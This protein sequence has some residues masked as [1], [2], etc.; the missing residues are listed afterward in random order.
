[1]SS[2]EIF[3]HEKAIC[4]SDEVGAGTRI[5]AFAHVMK[6]A[7]V[8]RSCNLGENVF[9]ESRAVVGN[10][11]TIKNGV[12]LWDKVTI[13]DKVFIG[14]NVSFTNVLRP[15]AFLK[16]NQEGFFPIVV[17]K[18]ATIGA[19]ATILCGTTIGEFAFVGAAAFVRGDVPA[20]ALVV[21]NPARQV[22]RVCFCGERLDGRD[23]CSLCQLLLSQNSIQ[24]LEGTYAKHNDSAAGLRVLGAEPSP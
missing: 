9:V 24:R 19:N 10:G 2:S 12:C 13:E 14:P 21:G 7:Q 3:V 5:W 18:G 8:G 20:H 11:V 22:G 16:R 1:M 6:G 23:F 4:E 15:R 17:K